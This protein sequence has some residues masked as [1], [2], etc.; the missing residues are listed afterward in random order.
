LLRR[1]PNLQKLRCDFHSNPLVYSALSQWQGSNNV[2][3]KSFACAWIMWK[4]CPLDVPH[5]VISSECNPNLAN[6][7]GLWVITPFRFR[8][9]Y[10]TVIG[11]STCRSVFGATCPINEPSSATMIPT[12]RIHPLLCAANS[13]SLIDTRDTCAV[14]ESHLGSKKKS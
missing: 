6:P 1:T 3:P 9:S 7:P 2:I 12:K 4:Q 5:N 11:Q 13:W 14:C 10:W 8:T